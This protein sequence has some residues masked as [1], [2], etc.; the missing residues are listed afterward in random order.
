[1]PNLLSPVGRG[2]PYQWMFP[3]LTIDAAVTH[4]Y[5][6]GIVSDDVF[7]K[8]Q[9]VVCCRTTE[10]HQCTDCSQHHYNHRRHRISDSSRDLLFPV[11]C[12]WKLFHLTLTASWLDCRSVEPRMIVIELPV[13]ACYVM[14]G[15]TSETTASTRKTVCAGGKLS[16]M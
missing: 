13:H 4:R 15:S 5:A 9:F 10:G 7:L 1:M 14:Q 6:T 11:S 12:T 2:P 8:K 3:S 16:Y